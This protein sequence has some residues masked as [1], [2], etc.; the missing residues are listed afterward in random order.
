MGELNLDK[1]ERALLQEWEDK[2]Y[3]DIWSHHQKIWYPDEDR[4]AFEVVQSG[5]PVLAKC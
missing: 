2:R 4:E 5:Q 3:K 1:I